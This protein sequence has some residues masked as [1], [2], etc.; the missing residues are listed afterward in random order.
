[1]NK[2]E[3]EGLTPALLAEK[4]AAFEKKYPRLRRARE[5]AEVAAGTSPIP[6]PKP[7]ETLEEMFGKKRAQAMRR[8]VEERDAGSRQSIPRG[9]RE[10]DN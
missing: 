6:E 9:E 2:K 8:E 3:E 10:E 5:K 1:M 4:I 7:R